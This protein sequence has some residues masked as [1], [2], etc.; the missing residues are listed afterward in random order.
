LYSI[1]TMLISRYADNLVRQL[2]TTPKILI[3]VGPRQVGKTTLIKQVLQEKGGKLL[4]FDVEVDKQRFLAAGSL[5]PVDAIKSLGNPLVLALDEAQRL[6]Q[7]ARILKGWYDRGASVKMILL[8]SSSLDLLDQS[9]ESLTGR[10]V[11]LFLPPFLFDEIIEAESWYSPE[12]SRDKLASS[13]NKQIETLLLQSIVFGSYPEAVTA[14]D[15]EGYLLNLVSDYLLKDVFQ[16]GIIKTPELIKKIILLL[17]H[18][19]GAEVSVNELS[20]AA[21]ISRPTVERYLELLERTFVIFRLPSF[22]TN[23]RKEISK[24]Q[25][26]FFWD[27]GVRNALL[28]EFSFSPLRGDIGKLWENWVI[29]E[30]AKRNAFNGERASLYFWRTRDGSEVD[31]VV[32]RGESLSAYEIKWNDKARERTLNAFSKKY[33]VPVHLITPA[34]AALLGEIAK[35]IFI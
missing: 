4:N 18:Q 21:G 17:A 28:K 3:V 13:F 22:S 16:S 35:S 24:S 10:N 19:A 34:R 23:P 7:A 14:S 20:R 1:V 15:K 2:L 31:L 29:A 8:G 9:A 25:K 6:P 5:D 33:G 32:R 27:T 11:K 30:F 26:I 12:F